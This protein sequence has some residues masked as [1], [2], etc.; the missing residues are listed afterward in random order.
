MMQQDDVAAML[1]ALQMCCGGQLSHAPEPRLV[2]V[3]VLM[4]ESGGL[5]GA[6]MQRLCVPAGTGRPQVVYRCN[7]MLLDPFGGFSSQGMPLYCTRIAA[8]RSL[9]MRGCEAAASG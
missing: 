9:G 6:V 8:R 3:A 4:E 1:L 5:D 7:V 2:N